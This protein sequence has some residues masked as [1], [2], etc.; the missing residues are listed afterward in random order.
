[1]LAWEKFIES[2]TAELGHDTVQKWLKPLRILKFDA[3]NL[4][5]EADD[6]FQ[7]IWFEEHIRPKLPTQLLNNNRKRIKIHLNVANSPAKI[8][9]RPSKNKV[10]QAEEPPDFVLSFDEPDPLCTFS[11]F[12][13][14]E[15]NLL[16][17]KVLAQLS[18]IEKNDPSAPPLVEELNPIYL[19]GCEGSGKSHMLMAAAQTLRAQGRHVIYSRA[20]TFTDHVVSAIRAGEMSLFR[21]AYR[22]SDVLIIDDLHVFSRKG[23]TQE[24]FFHTFNTLHM[25]G[26]QMILGANC[27]PGELQYI[28]PRL[29]SRFEWGIVLSLE[30]PSRKEAAE[31]LKAKAEALQYALPQK[32]MDFLL[33][34]FAS[35]KSLEK[36]LKALILRSHLN[37]SSNKVASAQLTVPMA[38]QLLSDLLLEEEKSALT[39][40]R[41]IQGVSEFFGIRPEDVLGKAQTRDCVLPR[42]ISMYLCRHQLKMPY[43]KIGELFEKDHST[44]M[45]SAKLIQKGIDSDDKE[46]AAAYRAILKKLKT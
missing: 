10:R 3:C 23:A 14:S 18:W 4:Y 43:M 30:L 16:T 35:T 19:Y 42:Q 41:I 29:I 31:I 46:I 28:E 32:V 25:A 22:N 34:S 45:S 33:D 6:A 8:K 5:L 1:M 21:Q 36:A 2:Q 38:R 9:S 24:E 44:V 37:G 20:Q 15:A 7:V 17:Y 26:K 39:P 11:N 13:I 27:P 12:V 40:S